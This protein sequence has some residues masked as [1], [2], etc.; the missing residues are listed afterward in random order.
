VC[1]T[2]ADFAITA[3]P[4]TTERA[5]N[6]GSWT[7]PLDF[8]APA[9]TLPVDT[10][11]CVQYWS[12]AIPASMT[13]FA[14]F[15]PTTEKLRFDLFSDETSYGL[16]YIPLVLETTGAAQI[17][18]TQNLPVYLSKPGCEPGSMTLTSA[19]FATTTTT[20]IT[21]LDTTEMFTPS[22]AGC[23]MRY[24]LQMTS[25]DPVETALVAAVTY[26]C[27]F[28]DETC[29][30]TMPSAM[31]ERDGVHAVSVTASSTMNV[32]LQEGAS[33][34]AA[35]VNTW[36][37]TKHQPDCESPGAGLSTAVGTLSPPFYRIGTST[38]AIAW[39]AWTVSPVDCHL[40]YSVAVAS[41]SAS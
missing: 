28:T 7:L 19:A 3:I 33:L 41:G 13:A 32:A 15:S 22:L 20:D 8:D 10:P 11:V 38:R 31:A 26:A 18:S 21:T 37:V 35:A 5:Y 23:I 25:T 39:D 29:A 2:V 12:S 14:D 6:I 24:V 4:A 27:D 1:E 30:I 16:R 17:G 40:L 9:Y 36:T 34:T